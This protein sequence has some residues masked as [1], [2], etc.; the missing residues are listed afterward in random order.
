MM[1][2][3][4]VVG[5]LS[6]MTSQL[7]CV[8]AIGDTPGSNSTFQFS[9]GSALYNDK[10]SQLWTATGDDLLALDPS[11]QKY[12]ISYT[13]S[14]NPDNS[15]GNAILQTYPNL[16]D[17]STVTEF[18]SSLIVNTG[19]A[20][21]LFGQAC[22]DLTL[23][24]TA[25]TVVLNS[26]LKSVYLI[27]RVSFTDNNFGLT[28][29]AGTSIVNK[30]SYADG[31][32]IAAIGGITT[33]NLLTAYAPGTFG[34]AGSKLSYVQLTP[35]AYVQDKLVTTYSC[36]KEQA[37]LNINTGLDV[38]KA[39]TNDLNAIGSSVAMHPSGTKMYVGLDVISGTVG[40]DCAV[41]LFTVTGTNS[42]DEVAGTLTPASVL[43]DSVAQDTG[44][45]TVVSVQGA[46]KQV[47]IRNVTT[48]Y[49]ST[50]FGYLIVSRDAGTGGSLQSI[51]AMPMVTMPSTNSD[52]GKI[53]KFDSVETLFK[54]IGVVYRQQGFSEI[55]D[56]A[57]EINIH[58]S[59]TVVD[60]LLVGGTIPPVAAGQHVKQLIA[61]GDSVYIVI[62]DEFGVGTTPGIF[63]S[64]ALF[65]DTGRI[66]SWTRWQRVVGTDDQVLFAMN[67]KVS[68]ST[69]FVSAPVS[70]T[71]PVF[72][73][74]QQTT[75]NSNS[76]LEAFSSK[77]TSYLPKNNGGVQGNFPFPS[78]TSGFTATNIEVSL[79][80]TTGNGN[81]LV[82][83]TGYLDSGN[84][85]TLSQTADTSILIDSS[86]GL[87]IGSVV[88]AAFGNAGAT[89]NWLFMGGDQG[90][91]VLSQDDGAGFDTLPNTDAAAYL[92]AAGQTC[93]TIGNF[94]FVKKIVNAGS[95]LYVMTQN[96]VYKIAVNQNKFKATNPAALDPVEIVRAA[97]LAP[98]AY[99]VDMIVDSSGFILLGTT[100]GLYS[101]LNDDVT[102]TPIAVPE[103]LA[104]ISKIQAISNS[105][106][107][108]NFY[109]SS[110]L[111]ILSIDY[112]TEQA[113][114]NR[115]VITNGVLT[116]IQDQLLQGQ[117]GPLLIFDY[118]SNN[119]F[120]D[121]SFGYATAY[122]MG[123]QPAAVTYLQYTLRGGVSGRHAGL[124]DTTSS[125]SIAPIAQS[126]SITTINRDF[127]SGS[128]MLA[129]DFGLLTLS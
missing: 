23:V 105:T 93:K 7:E 67:N 12:G 85:K 82:A 37:E 100:A 4:L 49:T 2:K 128:L 115:F 51:Y 123:T 65:D 54:L 74:I 106:N 64:Q 98:F 29:E 122:K 39:G 32:E 35:Q 79:L 114:L 27:E 116:P 63:T 69:M 44:V 87:S 18:T 60:R 25:P 52:F 59:S 36:L 48:T 66:A 121:G 26:D 81:V 57:S 119:M 96:S 9:I 58:G 84:F 104:N 91:S 8:V 45:T 76:T 42:T 120:I 70:A 75:W 125:V 15:S 50:G 111:Y 17:K 56:D 43:P 40:T 107:I 62:Q 24:G 95:H 113:R 112:V 109:A 88:A 61:Q 3:L 124:K 97:D 103:G 30:L 77:V 19:V 21:P 73:T 6:I 110:N 72:D 13:R 33:T 83:Q 89:A 94:K 11:I 46:N 53:A 86:L 20:N 99:C 41:G 68:G 102:I 5:F 101:I 108:N 10:D 47:A 38:L 126:K 127:A 80:V 31:S 117:D 28:S 34:L 22:R 92:I 14:I 78:N 1:K 16:T 118:M 71:T 90:L 129:A 55:I